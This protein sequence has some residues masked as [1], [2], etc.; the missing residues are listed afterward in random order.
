MDS[1]YHSTK[2]DLLLYNR[3]KI[4]FEG[5]GTALIAVSSEVFLHNNVEWEFT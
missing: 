5:P 1:Q 4:E 3:L 2:F